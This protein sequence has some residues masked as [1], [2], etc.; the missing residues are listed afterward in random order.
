MFFTIVDA[1]VCMLILAFFVDQIVAPLWARIPLFPM[2]RG[3]SDLKKKVEKTKVEWIDAKE[4]VELTKQLKVLT[5]ELALLK[6]K[7]TVDNN[8]VAPL[9][10]TYKNV[11]AWWIPSIFTFKDAVSTS[12]PVE[13][14]SQF[15]GVVVWKAGNRFDNISQPV[16][17]KN[18]VTYY[19]QPLVSATP[20]DQ[21]GLQSWSYVDG[22][23]VQSSL[24]K[25]KL[26]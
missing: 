3:K 17:D 10:L 25:I 23:L 21:S 26:T 2:F 19:P 9:E 11:H 4:Q 7:P 13:Y 14:Q 1:L 18:G 16:T 12:C 22:K 24:L 20:D 6:S 15:E 5:D 8:L